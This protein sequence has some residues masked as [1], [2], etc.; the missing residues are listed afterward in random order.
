MMAPPEMSTPA[1][2]G[3]G[4]TGTTAAAPFFPTPAP[5]VTTNPRMTPFQLSVNQQRARESMKAATFAKAAPLPYKP[6]PAPAPT[7]LPEASPENTVQ[8]DYNNNRAGQMEHAPL[9]YP[10]DLSGQAQPQQAPTVPG[11]QSQAPAGMQ[12]SGANGVGPLAEKTAQ[13]ARDA[14]VQSRTDTANA[15]DRGPGLGVNSYANAELQQ[16]ANTRANEAATAP[17]AKDEYYQGRAAEANARAEK[18]IPEQ[19]AAVKAKGESTA[20][21][22]Q[23]KADNL[24]A[25]TEATKAKGAA[26]TANAAT[27]AKNALTKQQATEDRMLVEKLKTAEQKLRGENRLSESAR[28]QVINQKITDLNRRRHI[29]VS[30]GINTADPGGLNEQINKAIEELNPKAPATQPAGGVGGVPLQN[31]PPGTVGGGPATQ[32]SASTGPLQGHDPQNLTPENL[33]HTASLH[34]ITVEEV[35]RRLQLA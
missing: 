33:Q 21:L 5:Q 25:G 30:A 29:A 1:P 24:A 9:F 22:T 8:F 18:L 12:Y 31:N 2:Y 27:N 32:P 11:F 35:K 17:N 3:G 15:Q 7:T 4:H 6:I 13:A 23:P 20:A 19:A 14:Y 34:G 16:D 10:S 28:R 26:A